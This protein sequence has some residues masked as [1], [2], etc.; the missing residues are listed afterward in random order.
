MAAASRNPPCPSVRGVERS[1]VVSPL[2]NLAPAPPTGA[3]LNHNQSILPLRDSRISGTATLSLSPDRRTLDMDVRLDRPQ[4]VR[5][6]LCRL[7]PL[8][9]AGRRVGEGDLLVAEIVASL[10][11]GQGC[12]VGRQRFSLARRDAFGPF[13]ETGELLATGICLSALDPRS[14]EGMQLDPAPARRR[15]H[16]DP[17]EYLTERMLMELAAAECSATAVAASRHVELATLYARR[18]RYSGCAAS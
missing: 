6:R 16:L 17:I 1:V 11:R 2:L 9:A 12:C 3:R 14:V 13:A 10:P 18:L 7:D 5:I 4:A 15:G 8:H